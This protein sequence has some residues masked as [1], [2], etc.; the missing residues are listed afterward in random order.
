MPGIALNLAAHRDGV[1]HQVKL[2]ILFKTKVETGQDKFV[3]AEGIPLQD[4]AGAASAHV[5]REVTVAETLGQDKASGGR[6]KAVGLE[7]LLFQHIP[8]RIPELHLQF[9]VCA[10]GIALLGAALIHHQFELERVPGIVC[11]AVPVDVAAGIGA[12]PGAVIVMQAHGAGTAVG[13]FGHQGIIAPGVLGN[14]LRQGLGKRRK[15]V[16]RNRGRGL[17]PAALEEAELHFLQRFTA[18][19]VRHVHLP[20]IGRIA[21]GYGQGILIVNGAVIY[22]ALAHLQLVRAIG[23]YGHGHLQGIR[24]VETAHRVGE[25][26]GFHLL[27]VRC[28]AFVQHQRGLLQVLESDFGRLTVCRHAKVLGREPVAKA[29]YGVIAVEDAGFFSREGLAVL[30]KGLA[31]VMQ[32]LEFR[33]RRLLAGELFHLHLQQGAAGIQAHRFP[34]IFGLQCLQGRFLGRFLV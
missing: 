21:H 20:A 6:S 27:A 2:V 14:G 32:R 7:L 29:L 28:G 24:H 15:A 34:L 18:L 3:H 22:F 1:A 23:Q 26:P 9:L 11:T 13:G 16:L 4:A 25:L 33:M 17:L 30:L 5:K 10:N 31:G 8:F 12:V 19:V